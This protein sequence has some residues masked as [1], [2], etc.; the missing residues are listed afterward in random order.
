MDEEPEKE[1][2]FYIEGPDELRCV[3]M[4]GT[5]S[6]DPWSQNLGSQDKVAEALS[7]WLASIDYDEAKPKFLSR[8]PWKMRTRHQ[9][10]KIITGITD[11]D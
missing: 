2:L 1:A 6:C 8:M 4:H 9:S 10:S 7:Q 11:E 5:S 3:W